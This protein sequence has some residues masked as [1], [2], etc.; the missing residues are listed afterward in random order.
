[1]NTAPMASSDRNGSTFIVVMGMT[2]IGILAA[3]SIL[4][5][6]LSRMRQADH[7]VCLEQAFYIAAAGAERA[8]SN[9]AAGNETSTTLEGSLGKGSYAVN[10]VCQP[11]ATGSDLN[12]DITSC[13]TVKTVSHTVSLRG[14]RRVS[15]ARYALWYDTE[16]AKLWIVPGERFDG[17]VY[18]KPQLHFHDQNLATKGQVRFTDRVSTV[19]AT[20]EKASSAV[21]PVFEQGLTTSAEVESMASVDFT[22]LLTAATTGGLVLEG[23]TT[24]VLDGTA[25]KITNSRAGWT[26]KSVS[27]PANGTIY[28]KTVTAT[29]TTTRYGKTTT[30]T[31]TY[32]GDVDV[33]S[34]NGLQGRLT[35]VADNDINI[36]D[37]VR[38]KTNP[39]T[40]PTS[41]DA[42]GLV[43][44]QD[45]VVATTAPNNVEIF[46]HMIAQ[47]GGFGVANYSSGTTRGVLKVYGGIVNNVRN[48]VGI[49]GGAGYTKNYIFDTRLSKNPPPNYPKLLDELEWTEWDG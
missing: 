33:S 46:A 44:K 48:A 49:V 37:H 14:I 36:V 38:Y 15:W 34:P 24:I 20:I 4:S 12:I 10:V 45:V 40:A 30:T 29:T 47:T 16:A 11:A 35:V 28:A 21:N 13:G 41:T 19:P 8:A 32:P 17:R 5:S 9:V 39:E 23:P 3:G 2:M 7:Q 6:V 26:S 43:A 22:A 25:I 1:M 18:S 27:L 42:L 31:T